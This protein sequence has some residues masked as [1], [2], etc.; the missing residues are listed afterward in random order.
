[1]YCLSWDL[2]DPV[3]ADKCLPTLRIG[4]E[5]EFYRPFRRG[6]DKSGLVGL[7]VCGNNPH[8]PHRDPDEGRHVVVA[9]N[10][11]RVPRCVLPDREDQEHQERGV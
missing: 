8:V 10:R 9:A 7:F 11:G 4:D 1:M 3:V 2:M 5:N 6:E